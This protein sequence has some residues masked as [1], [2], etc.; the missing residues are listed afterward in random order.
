[1]A[2]LQ[3]DHRSPKSHHPRGLKRDRVECEHSATL[4]IASSEEYA[5][6]IWMRHE[7]ADPVSVTMNPGDAVIYRGDQV[8]HWRDPLPIEW[9]LQVFLHFVDADGPYSDRAFDRRAGLGRSD[10]ERLLDGAR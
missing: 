8:I 4:H 2:H 3:V 9:Y 1:M 5:W 10:R 7:S 6:P